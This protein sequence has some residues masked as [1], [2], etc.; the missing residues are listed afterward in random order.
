MDEFEESAEV[1]FVMQG[2]VVI[3]YEINKSKRYCLK[4]HSAVVIGDYAMTFNQRSQFIYTALT[5]LHAL[6]IRKENWMVLLM[7]NPDIG[8][9]IISKIFLKYLTEIKSKVLVAKRKATKELR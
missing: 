3:G 4:L 9:K 8:G 2:Q 6:F 1:I 5:D 7:E